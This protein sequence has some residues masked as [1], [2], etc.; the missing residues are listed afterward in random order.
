MYCFFKTRKCERKECIGSHLERKFRLFPPFYGMKF[1]SEKVITRA[2]RKYYNLF[3]DHKLY[4]AFWSLLTLPHT[5][6]THTHCT[7]THHICT[8]STLNPYYITYLY[9]NNT[10]SLYIHFVVPLLIH[11]FRIHLPFSVFTYS[12]IPHLLTSIIFTDSY[13]PHSLRFVCTHSVISHSLTFLWI[14]SFS[15]SEF[16]PF[17]QSFIQSIIHSASRVYTHSFITH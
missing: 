2:V 17:I 15:H 12:F 13:I 5:T 9:T 8:L 11:S 10:H 3:T 4:D 14:H 7:L 1:K 16:I 6:L